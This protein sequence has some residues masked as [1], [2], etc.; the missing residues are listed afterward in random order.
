MTLREFFAEA[1][2]R[3]RTV[4]AFAPAYPTWLADWFD[5]R[6]VDVE[7]EYLPAREA[8]PFLVVS[9]GD[10]FLGSVDM[11]AVEAMARP[12][13]SDPGTDAFAEAVYRTFL[14]M[15]PDA[16]FSSF[17]RRQ[18]LAAA[19]EIED[20][21]VRAGRGVL[22]AG[23]QSRDAFRR[24]SRLYGRLASE[25]DLDVR[26]Y[27]AADWD[28]P[29]VEGVTYYG[30]PSD[31][32]GGTAPDD[33]GASAGTGGGAPEADDPIDTNTGAAGE[34]G[35]F[36]FVAFDG[37]ADVFQSCALLAEERTPGEFYGFWTYDPALVGRLVT[38]LRETYP[39]G[40]GD[41]PD[42]RENET[43]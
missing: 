17:D 15:L 6:H 19:R 20:R 5:A 23:F 39:D 32:S 26:V 37:G 35:R 10:E 25:T 31:G 42:H 11:R 36:W 28:P 33:D 4:T 7:Y 16:L 22:A 2:S 24:Q 43:P 12:A 41:G 21:A 8:D 30:D 27:G 18:M 9:E 34:L 40:A 38:Y 29:P 3:R 14:S 1:E 13:V